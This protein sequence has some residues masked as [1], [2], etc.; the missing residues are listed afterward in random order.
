MKPHHINVVIQK[1]KKHQNQRW[2]P[3]ILRYSM[4]LSSFSCLKVPFEKR[5]TKL[6]AS[7]IPYSENIFSLSYSVQHILLKF[8]WKHYKNSFVFKNNSPNTYAF[9]AYQKLL[10]F[11][12][13]INILHVNTVVAEQSFPF[14]RHTTA[15]HSAQVWLFF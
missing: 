1:K 13:I 5:M 14:C 15:Q 3:S 2:V 9:T 8:R 12:D 10:N 11:W 4:I 7:L 6:H